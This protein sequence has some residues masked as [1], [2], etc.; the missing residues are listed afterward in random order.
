MDTKRLE[1]FAQ[2]A[3]KELISQTEIKLKQ[4]LE[5]MSMAR[6]ENNKIVE[7]LEKQI[8]ESSREEVISRTA[9]TWFNRFCALRFMDVHGYN[10]IR[11]LSPLE[12]QFQPEILAEAKQGI[13]DEKIVTSA[14]TRKRITELLGGAYKHEDPQ[15]EAYRL[16]L[17]SVC[18]YWQ[19]TMPFLFE[20]IADYTEIL[21][22][23][24]L[25]SGN[26]ILAYTREAMT[27]E[28][29]EDVEVIGW[30]YQFYIS[31]K[32]DD[33]FAELK[34]GKKIKPSD[35]P[36]ATQLFTPDWIVRYLVEN[37]LGRLWM[38]NHPNSKLLEKMP[39]YIKP[40][41]I[42]SE[43]LKI[44]SPEEIRF[45]DPACG[46]GHIL[47]Y[48][49]DL[50]Y[51]IYSKAGYDQLDIPELILT[52]NLFGIEIDKRAGEL[53]AFALTMKAR[54]KN[55]RFFQK[56]IEPNVLVLS[57]IHF[58]KEEL[59]EYMNKV[60]PD[61]FTANLQETLLCF[62]EADN[63]GSLIRPTVTDVEGVLKILKDKGVEEHLFL[64]KTHNQ[65]LLALKQA[66]YLNPKYHLVVANPPYMG[67]KGM[68]DRLKKFLQ[69]NYEESKADLFAVFMVRS[70]ELTC[71]K[72][73]MGM[74]NMQSWM[75][76]SSFE[77]LRNSILDL[78]TIV[79]M[80]H[81]G[82]RAFDSIGGEVVS[83]T[84]FTIE[85]HNRIDYKG[86]FVRLIDGNSEKEK[87][88][89]LL[90]AI[91]N[92]NCGWFYRASTSDFKKIPGSPIAYWVSKKIFECFSSNRPLSDFAF[93][94]GKNIT[95]NNNLFQRY[96]WEVSGSTVGS[97][98]K[99]AFISKG[100]GFKR[101]IENK[102]ITIDWSDAARNHYKEDSIGRIIPEY[103]RFRNGIS[104]G[105]ITSSLPSFRYL[106]EDFTFS[107]V[108]LFFNNDE[109]IDPV[110][111]FLNSKVANYFLSLLNPTLNYPMEIVL[112]LPVSNILNQNS[113]LVNGIKKIANVNSITYETSW[114]FTQ[115]P[116]LSSA[117]EKVT[118]RVEDA[119]TA[120]R[121][122]WNEMTLEMKR[123]E[124][125]NNRIFID[126]YGLQDE[127][128]P[129]VPLHEITLTCNPYYRY[130]KDKS[131][132]ELEV[133]LLAD[134]IREFIS[135][136]VGC[137]FGRYSLDKP[138]LIL[139]NQG[140][141]VKEYLAKLN[142][143]ESKISFP[144]DDDNIIPI[145]EGDWFTD[146][147]SERFTEFL[148]ITF[149]EKNLDENL[150]FIE[151]ALGKRVRDYF[152]KDFYNDHVKRY[153]KRPIYWL[154]TSP[155]GSFNVL[156]YMHR[157]TPE[158]VGVILNDYMR[159]FQSKLTNRRNQLEQISITGTVT[160]KT[161]ALK[162]IEKIKKIFD[163]L[164]DYER[165]IMYPLA[166]KKIAIDLDDGVKVNYLKFGKALKPI[167]GLD[168]KDE[169]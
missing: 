65:V 33:V 7:D 144:P 132:E 39:Y 87:S 125:E 114:D 53:A 99:W 102:D 35:I 69:E 112:K 27:P 145:L 100:G 115:L 10:S 47:V 121:N 84:A 8:Q 81:L 134:T 3:R 98:L 72:G 25:L 29:C 159:E 6:R 68:N 147:I 11:V 131:K 45:C 89:K 77:N 157:Y 161:K 63:L 13:L 61:L 18:N 113:N 58:K 122:N 138:G 44:N 62:E 137:M 37:T 139:A 4:V 19:T 66:E 90:E 105:L 110:I 165:D 149:G 79:T 64:S 9:Y 23:S 54:A 40:D 120:L 36:A 92:P 103:I 108:G 169:D 95:G 20:K 16:L 126:A 22:P 30:L 146:D 56:K 127:L 28:N 162:E 143:E 164:K 130:D 136:A 31:E 168:T 15:T 152:V 156:I 83:T 32:K 91:K 2:Y 46:S 82:A 94:D 70:L 71:A 75:F 86:I 150:L 128:T 163:E 101:W 166:G 123:L 60:Q 12:G 80:A 96:F 106:N 74:V 154:F 73:M 135:Y 17:V 24:D 52:K 124:E 42:E 151:R 85:N 118:T 142:I 117:K 141:G 59:T 67:G 140:E 14:Q 50:L 93:S 155:K 51:E 78:K 148:N 109:H 116:L 21:M 38:L 119:Y 111:S 55:R 153:K 97:K 107:D 167:S 48:A 129:D 158:T 43:F 133:L 41:S 1:R 49:F 104:W 76:L 5:P 160:E 57:N 26:S 88:S 34:K